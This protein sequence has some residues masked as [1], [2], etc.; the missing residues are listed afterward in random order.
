[1]DKQGI[2]AVAQNSLSDLMSLPG[3]IL[4]SSYNTLKP[5]DVYFLGY[6]PGGEGPDGPT[7]ADRLEA[8]PS[9]TCNDFTDLEWGETAAAGQSTLQLRV[10]WLLDSL[11]Y[12]IEDVCSSNLIFAQSRDAKGVPERYANICWPVHEAI[13]ALVKPKL[14]LCCGNSQ[15]SSFGYLQRKLDGEIQYSPKGV[16]LH[17]DWAIKAFRTELNGQPILVVG[18]PHLSRYDPIGKPQIIEWIKQL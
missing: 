5:G 14:I 8:L 10:K 15:V 7:V 16:A 17:G 9:K 12:R 1:M 4:Y 3:A 6:N 18:F 13:L 11:G 2:L